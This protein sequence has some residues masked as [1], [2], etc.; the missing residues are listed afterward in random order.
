MSYRT[1][2]GKWDILEGETETGNVIIIISKS[3]K[4]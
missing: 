2:E 1:R 4:F 3:L